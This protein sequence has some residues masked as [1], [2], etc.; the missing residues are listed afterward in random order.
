LSQAALHTVSASA[1]SNGYLRNDISTKSTFRFDLP[2]FPAT[3]RNP[4]SGYFN[5]AR[6]RG[7]GSGDSFRSF[8]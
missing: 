4:S 7:H 6:L 2:R 3:G 8:P 5:S 1:I